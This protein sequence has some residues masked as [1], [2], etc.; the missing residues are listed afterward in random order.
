MSEVDIF[1]KLNKAWPSGY[2]TAEGSRAET[3]NN[4]SMNI[5]MMKS[6][7]NVSINLDKENS[8]RS[9]SSKIR[10]YD[11][12]DFKK[13]PKKKS[14]LQ[15]FTETLISSKIQDVRLLMEKK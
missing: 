12:P 10:N 15:N 7:L 2:R 11:H 1:N 3:T 9:L 13:E 6:L 5:R 14:E 8:D 4:T